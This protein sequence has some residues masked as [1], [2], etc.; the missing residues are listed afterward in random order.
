M[1]NERFV[2]EIVHSLEES[3]AEREAALFNQCEINQIYVDELMEMGGER[4]WSMFDIDVRYPNHLEKDLQES[5]EEITN[6]IEEA[7]RENATAN[8]VCVRNFM[9]IPVINSEKTSPV[10][11]TVNNLIED[12]DSLQIHREW[13]KA[14]RRQKTD[15]EGAITSAR[16]LLEATCKKILSD[17]G[18]DTGDALTLPQM[19]RKVADILDLAPSKATDDLIKRLLG[20]CQSIVTTLGALRNQVGDAHGKSPDYAPMA[21]I[22]SELAVNLSG[23]MALFLFSCADPSSRR[24]K[25]ET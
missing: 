11:K 25:G 15:P 19:Y 8:G 16:T 5:W 23:S 24:D 10:T 13:Q 6:L 14:L 21:S 20:N 2:E 17:R 1:S 12:L 18:Q 3:G 9:W 7:I 22:H 4:M